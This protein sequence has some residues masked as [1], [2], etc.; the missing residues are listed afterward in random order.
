MIRAALN[1]STDE[2]QT[3]ALVTALEEIEWVIA[4]DKPAAN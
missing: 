1:Q 2:I 3:P 4:N